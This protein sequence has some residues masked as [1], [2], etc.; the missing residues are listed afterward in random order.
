MVICGNILVRSNF[1]HFVLI[2]ALD[3][4]CSVEMEIERWQDFIRHIR[5]HS[6]LKPES[7]D[8]EDEKVDIRSDCEEDV[9]ASVKEEESQ[10]QEPEDCL[11]EAM[12]VDF[13]VSSEEDD[14]EDEDDV[15]NP[16]IPFDYELETTN[17]N[18]FPAL[19]KV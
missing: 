3:N 15:D 9:S 2:C 12:F 14:F 8:T 11:A 19:T 10:T 7:V 16:S 1:E 4:D 18:D 17:P 5:E 6:F 13:P